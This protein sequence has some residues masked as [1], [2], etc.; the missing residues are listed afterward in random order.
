MVVVPPDMPV[1]TPVAETEAFELL[2]LQVPPATDALRDI[3]TPTQTDAGPDMV[4]DAGEGFTVSVAAAT[5]L[6][7]LFDIT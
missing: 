1:T 5:V 6:P 3:E 4:T 7:Q 2:L